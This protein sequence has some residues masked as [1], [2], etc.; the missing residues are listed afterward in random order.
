V[1]ETFYPHLQA[2]RALAVSGPVALHLWPGTSEFGGRLAGLGALGVDLFFVISGF[3]IT[4]ILLDARQRWRSG[5]STLG[6]VLTGFY[7]RRT[8]RIFPV[9]WLLLVVL[10]VAGM[11]EVRANFGWEF[12]YLT[13]VLIARRDAWLSEVESHFWSLAVEEQFYLAW[14]LLVLLLPQR[15]LL[16]ALLAGVAA[17]P[18]WR[19]YA[20]EQGSL[21]DAVVLTPGCLDVLALGGLLAL[22]WRE[23]VA[24]P[25][26]LAWFLRV[27]AAAG[28][29]GST[30]H[31]VAYLRGDIAWVVGAPLARTSYALLF[32]ALV[33]AA[34]RGLP[35]LA[36]R[37][38]E[39][40]PVLW[41]GTV[42]YAVYL[43]HPVVGLLPGVRQ[44]LAPLAANWPWAHAAAQI[45]LTLVA[46]GLSWRILEEPLARRRARWRLAEAT[47]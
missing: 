29:V 10:A 45:A 27:A 46:A 8:L 43:F 39:L 30:L 40:R 23:R 9:Y 20:L 36:G 6:G 21:H 5:G 11:G 14:P 26:R 19:V 22:L 34:A 1:S 25:E 41:L 3:L 7:A 12:T 42:S 28:T 2:L 37:L 47:P 32:T 15:A 13:N 44:L 4:G 17:G 35:G 18:L 38:A 24:H 31:V 16:P 33:A